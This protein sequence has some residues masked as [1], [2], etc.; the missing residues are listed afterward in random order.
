MVQILLILQENF[1]GGLKG[2]E[3]EQV[4]QV[5]GCAG[6]CPCKDGKVSG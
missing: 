2:V 4:Q 3:M 6:G 5:L 1:L